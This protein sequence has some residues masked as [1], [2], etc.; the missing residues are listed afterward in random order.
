MADD[1]LQLLLQ[2]CLHNLGQIIPIHEFGL[3]VGHRADFFVRPGNHG[4]IEVIRNGL[5]VLYHLIDFPGIGDHSFIGQ[6]LPQ[7]IKLRQHFL[8]STQ[9]QG[10]LHLRIIKAFAL[11]ED[12]TVNRV[13]RIQEMHIT[14]SHQHFPGFLGQLCHLEIDFPQIIIIIYTGKLIFALQKVVIVNGLNFQVI[15]EIHYLHQFLI[16]RACHNGTYELPRLA[17]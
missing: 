10:R 11:H 3:V 13:L 1:G 14:G 12:S 6:F 15:V 8:S 17:G 7:I 4:R 9:V 2:A 5:E 16:T